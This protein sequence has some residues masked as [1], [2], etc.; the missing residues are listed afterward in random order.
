VNRS[1]L[2]LIGND[3]TAA[4]STL[5]DYLGALQLRHLDGR[6]VMIEELSIRRALGG[7]VVTASQEIGTHPVTQRQISLLISAAPLREDGGRVVGAVQVLRDISELRELDRLK[8]EFLAVAAHELKTPVTITKGY[9]QALLRSAQGTPERQR[10][11]LESI[12]RGAD[13]IDGLVGDLLDIVRL[14][15]QGLELQMERFDLAELVE[16][17]VD[18]MAVAAPNH[19]LRLVRREPVVVSGDRGRLE[20]V[21]EN[22]LD[23]ALRYSPGGG[24][25][26]VAV[27]IEVGDAIVTVH[28]HGVGIP[29]DRQLRIGQRFYR[30]HTGTPFDYGG[31]GVGL[32][33][34]KEIVA[35]HDGSLWFKSEP[36][37]GSAFSFS[38][39]LR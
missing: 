19:H 26:D 17:T 13:R 39:P 37:R 4:V 36:G 31:M 29:A 7:E 10:K 21:L 9:A 5:E 3:D 28:D 22:L 16:E 12:V 30:A 27:S 23:N 8:D 18:R 6:P 11:M 25:V 20:Q 32:Y 38:L 14:H 2:A 34:A 33:I 24:N 1:G 35:R 15:S